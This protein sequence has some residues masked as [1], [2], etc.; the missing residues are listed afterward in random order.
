MSAHY[1]FCEFLSAE[2]HFVILSLWTLYTIEAC[3]RFCWEGNFVINGIE[4]SKLTKSFQGYQ[5][6]SSWFN[7]IQF[8]S[9]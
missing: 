1:M 8:I 6:T 5:V 7:S 4:T 3:G 9:S 2:Q